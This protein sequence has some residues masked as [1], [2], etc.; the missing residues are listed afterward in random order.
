MKTSITRLLLL[1]VVVTAVVAFSP[2]SDTKKALETLSGTYADTKAVDWGRGTFGTRVFTFDKGRWSLLF[3][4][5]LDPQMKQPVFVFRTVGSYKVLEKSATVPDAYNAL[6]I[7]DKK[8]VTLKTADKQLAQGFGLDQCGFDIDK[9][10]DISLTGCSLW[11]PV[12]E[13]NED[14]DLLALD[15]DGKLYFGLRPDDNNMCTA[16]KR[17]ARLNVPVVHTR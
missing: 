10:K 9:E 8:W 6:F 2:A 15:K 11:K 14:H 7:E 5:A 3:T 13:C 4:L 12:A 16:D 1:A 17:P